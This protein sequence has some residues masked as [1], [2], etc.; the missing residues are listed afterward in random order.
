M[1]SRVNARNMQRSLINVIYVNKQEFSASSWRSNQGYS[2]MH[3][4]Q[5]IKM[6]KKL[7]NFIQSK[8]FL[9]FPKD[10]FLPLDPQPNQLSLLVLSPHPIALRSILI[11]SS[12]LTFTQPVILITET[13]ITNIFSLPTLNNKN[14]I[15]LRTFCNG[16]KCNLLLQGRRIVQ[17]S[18]KVG[19]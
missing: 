10:L 16:A 7:P 5:T 13:L 14:L 17:L 4:Q 1:M 6:V 18:L 19:C 9:L 2:E 11:L 12:N 3:G 8:I 15:I